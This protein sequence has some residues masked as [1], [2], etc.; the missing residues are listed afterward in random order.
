MF[1]DL[2]GLKLQIDE[3]N[4]FISLCKKLPKDEADKLRSSRRARFEERDNHRKALEIAEASRPRNFW[5]Q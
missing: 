1:F 4:A 5:G 2:S 3:H